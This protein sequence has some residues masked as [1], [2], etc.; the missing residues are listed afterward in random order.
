M[1]NFRD[2]MFSEVAPTVNEDTIYFLI[3]G[4]IDM[5]KFEAYRTIKGILN[6]NIYNFINRS[7][8]DFDQHCKNDLQLVRAKTMDDYFFMLTINKTI[9]FDHHGILKIDLGRTQIY[10]YILKPSS[11]PIY[12]YTQPLYNRETINLNEYRS[13]L[14]E[15]G[16]KSRRRK[17]INIFRNLITCVFP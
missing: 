1:S 12:S 17:T 10:N 9:A 15:T 16:D 3:Y 13:L 2:F 8:I 14:S 6:N 4:D 5:S 7:G 11:G